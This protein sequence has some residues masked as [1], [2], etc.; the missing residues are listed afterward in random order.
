M[1]PRFPV[2]LSLLVLLATAATADTPAPQSYTPPRLSGRDRLPKIQAV[3]PEIAQLFQNFTAEQHLPGLVYGVLVDGGLIHTGTIGLA[4]VEAKIPVA[5]DTRFRI[6][7]MTKSFTAMAIFRLRDEGKLS[8][9]DPVE[10]YLPE[11]RSVAH[12]TADSSAI[13]IKHLLTM[14]AGFPEDNPWGDR[15]LGDTEEQLRGFLSGGLSLSNAPGFAYEYSNL[16]FAL[17]GQIITNISGQRYQD[18]IT[19]HILQP[20][21]MRDTHWEYTDIPADKLALGYRWEEGAWKQEPLLHDGTY[22]AMGGLITTLPDFARYVAFQLSAQPPCNDPETGPVRRATLREMQQ[23]ATFIRIVADAKTL[24]GQPNPFVTFYAHGL[25]WNRDARGNVWVR[26]AGGLPG[27]GSE[28]RF[29]PDHGVALI[30]FANRTY[31]PL[32]EVTAKALQILLEKGGVQPRRLPVSSLL[33][34][35]MRQVV[36]L[37][38]TWDPKLCDEILADNFLLDRTRE[39]WMKVA[40]EVLDQVGKIQSVGEV[41]PENQLRATFTL[42]GEKGSVKVFF[43]LTPERPPKIQELQLTFV[44]NP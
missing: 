11:F 39:R 9:A 7:S 17:L 16:G 5:L 32:N 15:R 30:A 40:R 24:D 35:R 19:K 13:T 20:L 37:I 34:Q 3:L 31:A 26:H 36:D 28:Y 38:N 23:P 1:N 18:Y 41:T 8:L 12:L 4:N 43:T 27:F 44:P 22:G 42:Q 10:K 14:S 21:G 33:S 6:A 2:L 25:G 29:C